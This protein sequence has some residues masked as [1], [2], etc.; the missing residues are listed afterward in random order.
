MA[1]QA[2]TV[3]ISWIK[4][5]AGAAEEEADSIFGTAVTAASPAQPE[6]RTQLIEPPFLLDNPYQKRQ[7]YRNVD[8]L[9][10]NMKQFGFKG[11]IPVRTHPH[12]PSHYQIAFGHRRV[13]AATLAGVPVRVE[14]EEISDEEMILLAI[15]ENYE[16]ED[17]TP[18]EEGNS[19]LELHESFGMSQEAIAA[20][21]GEEKKEKIARGYVRNRMRAAKL[22]RKYP[23]VQNFFEQ[24]PGGAGYLRSV[25]Y[26]EEEGM[27]VREVEFILERLDHDQWTA[28]TVA[29]AVKIL[30]AGGEAAETLLNSKMLTA[31]SLAAGD[32]QDGHSP[33]P[34]VSGQDGA[35]IET[36]QS[37]SDDS[38]LTLKRSGQVNDVLKRARRYTQ[39]IGDAAPSADERSTLEELL[40]IIQQV[41]AR[42]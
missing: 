29:A 39:L 38:A 22:A 7:V 36:T 18:L 26:L 2:K 25:G 30:K 16:R 5:R 11:S 19:F 23:Q 32:G 33:S 10:E 20:F 40:D 17:L 6:H 37:P 14:V 4:P 21:V 34:A 3:D 9:A 31:S 27:G 24:H 8:S 41:L 42:S 12:K 15:S 1:K 28:D 13:R 35:T